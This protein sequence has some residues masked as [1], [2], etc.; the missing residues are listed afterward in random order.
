LVRDII[1]M[2]SVMVLIVIGMVGGL[3]T[4]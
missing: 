1:P 3:I 2:L 4:P